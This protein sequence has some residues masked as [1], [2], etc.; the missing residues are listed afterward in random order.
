MVARA[1]ACIALLLAFN[2]ISAT[3]ALAR[4]NDSVIQTA[5][6]DSAAQSITRATPIATI[7]P[8]EAAGDG[9]VTAGYAIAR[10]SED[11]TRFRDPAL[12]DDRLDRLKYIPIG[13]C[14]DAYLSLSGGIRG[15][16]DTVSNPGARDAEKIRQRG[17]RLFAGG[18]LHLGSQVRFYG[19]VAHG[20]LAGD[21]ATQAG[22]NMRSTLIIQQAFG[23]VSTALNVGEVGVRYGRQIFADGPGQMVSQGDSSNI[24]V[25]LNGAR[26]WV[27]LRS[28]RADVFD[29][30]F[31]RNGPGGT[32]DDRVDHSQRF[33]GITAG[34]VL[35]QT[36]FGGSKLYLEPFAWRMRRDAVT[37]GRETALEERRF[38][39][40]RM[41]GDAGRVTL[42]WSANRQS[43]SFGA[44]SIDAWKVFAAQTVLLGEART[45]P[46][47]SACT[48]NTDRGAA[49]TDAADCAMRRHRCWMAAI[50][51][52]RMPSRR[53]TSSR[54]RP[55]SRS[56]CSPA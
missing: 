36:W 45:S 15:R 41:W 54:S 11:W 42:D 33:S 38:I 47:G 10:W 2:P 40:L 9:S 3:P 35:P 44:R 4:A 46:P 16:I 20:G 18:D 27:H 31:T 14:D 51:A 8:A 50:S 32:G 39:G 1:P 29:M 12:R 48:S 19:E 25:V 6:P 13:G 17:L 56:R 23:E 43:G 21:R 53:P 52:I 7:Y 26:G 30:K 37:F 5:T 34:I 24:Q 22:P 55:I 49:P 28:A